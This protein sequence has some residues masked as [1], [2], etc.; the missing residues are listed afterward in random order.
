MDSQASKTDQD[1]MLRALELAQ[2]AASIDEVPIG[3][4]VVLDHD[5]VTGTLLQTPEIVA[6]AYNIR[7]SGKNPVG[8]GELLA[9]QAAALKLGRWRLTGCTLYVTLEP[10][11]MCAGAIVLSRVSRVV[12]GTRDPK[13]GAVDSLYGIL[14]DERL[15]HRPKVLSGV[16]EA[17]CSRVLKEFFA[18]KRGLL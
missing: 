11:V 12:Y 9:L 14:K 10:C 5:P 6:E 15:N 4:L 16:C 18:K 1:F 3:A 17:E 2:E 8:H 13:A 7:E